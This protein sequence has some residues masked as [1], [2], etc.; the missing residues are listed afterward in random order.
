MA[1]NIEKL[2]VRLS[3]TGRGK[4]LHFVGLPDLEKQYKF[5]IAPRLKLVS[6]MFF[7]RPRR[8]FINCFSILVLPH[9]P[10]C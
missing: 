7:Q 2:R 8:I 10:E 9:L 1:L 6:K 3:D 5:T 4:M